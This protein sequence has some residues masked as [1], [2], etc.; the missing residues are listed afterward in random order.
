M[1][2]EYYGFAFQAD[3]EATEE[4][5]I[6][7]LP[8]ISVPSGQCGKLKFDL[9]LTLSAGERQAASSLRACWVL[10]VSLIPLESPLFTTIN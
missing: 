9:S 7:S 10:A 5:Q 4:V 3:I 2:L 8:S 6:P 1:K